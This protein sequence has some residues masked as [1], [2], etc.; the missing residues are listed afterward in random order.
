MKLKELGFNAKWVEQTAREKDMSEEDIKVAVRLF[1]E[2]N[3]ENWT[4]EDF[5]MYQEVSE[6]LQSEVRKILDLKP[7]DKFCDVLPA[8]VSEK[9]FRLMFNLKYGQASHQRH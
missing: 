9:A 2:G 7:T 8:E 5:A 3:M 4:P 6:Y 1:K